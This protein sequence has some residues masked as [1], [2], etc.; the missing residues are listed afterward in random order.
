MEEFDLLVGK[1]LKTMDKLLFLQSELERCQQIEEELIQ[2]QNET[3]I[4]SLQVEILQKKEELK[5][6]QHEFETQTEALIYTFQNKL[7]PTS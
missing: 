1:Q 6:I 2:I 4:T 5:R 7:L 3:T